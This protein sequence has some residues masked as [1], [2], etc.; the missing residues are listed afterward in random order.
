MVAMTEGFLDRALPAKVPGN[1]NPTLAALL[2]VLTLFAIFAFMSGWIM[3][4]PFSG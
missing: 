4:L 1:Y 3:V 2:L